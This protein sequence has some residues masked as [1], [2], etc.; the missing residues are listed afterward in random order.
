[1]IEKMMDLRIRLDNERKRLNV[2][3]YVIEQDYLLSWILFGISLVPEL[4]N[5]LAF[6][7]GTALKKCYFGE[8]RFSEDLD[9]SFVGDTN[10][11]NSLEQ[12]LQQAC[13]KAMELMEEYFPSPILKI[14]KYEEKQPHPDG[15]LAYVV[16]GQLPWHREPVV[17]VMLEITMKERVLLPLESRKIIHNYG[18][19]FDL[20]A[21]VYSLE[22][23]ISEKLRAILQYTKKLHENDWARSRT[24][25]YYDLWS[26]F[27]HFEPQIN[28]NIIKETLEKKCI[29]KQVSF[30]GINDFFDPIAIAEVHKTWNQWLGPLVIKLPET[31][32]VIEYIKEKL[33]IIFS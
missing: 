23:I 13:T 25:D 11:A 1:M 17:K 10:I 14:T 24:R 22:E 33:K 19:K 27:S 26:I 21:N 32:L 8:Y 3:F 6:K 15:Q 9:Y 2:P 12:C 20:T 31:N 5:Y 16:R 18:E 28:Y 29:G 4:N 7:G 30:T